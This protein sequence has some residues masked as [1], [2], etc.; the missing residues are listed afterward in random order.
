MFSAFAA[1]TLGN[2]ADH[3]RDWF[4]SLVPSEVIPHLA[5]LISPNSGLYT[6]SP[7]IYS[8]QF[9]QVLTG[10]HMRRTQLER[11]ERAV[12]DSLDPTSGMAIE[13]ADLFA[14]IEKIVPSREFA[15]PYLPL[16]QHMMNGIFT[17]LETA[18]K[19]LAANAWFANTP[20]TARMRPAVF[21]NLQDAF[22]RVKDFHSW[23]QVSDKSVAIFIMNQLAVCAYQVA[24]ITIEADDVELRQRSFEFVETTAADALST[25]L[26]TK[27][28]AWPGDPIWAYESTSLPPHLINARNQAEFVGQYRGLFD[29]RNTVYAN[30][31]LVIIYALIERQRLPGST[32]SFDTILQQACYSTIPGCPAAQ[33][34]GV[35]GYMRL[36]HPLTRIGPIGILFDRGFDCFQVLLPAVDTFLTS[37]LDRNKTATTPSREE[38]QCI[39]ANLFRH[40]DGFITE[41]HWDPDQF[42]TSLLRIYARN[43][44]NHF[45]PSN[46]Y[47][48]ALFRHAQEELAWQGGESDFE[49]FL[50][51]V[52]TVLRGRSKDLGTLRQGRHDAV[53]KKLSNLVFGLLPNNTEFFDRKKNI[54][55][56]D[57]LALWNHYE[58]CLTLYV[59][60]PEEHRPSL[61]LFEHLLDFKS[62]P[63]VIRG[64]TIDMWTAV[65]Q[66][67]VSC[68]V[69]S[70]DTK[71]LAEWAIRMLRCV[72][73][74]L[75]ILNDLDARDRRGYVAVLNTRKDLSISLAHLLR[76]WKVVTIQ[77]LPALVTSIIPRE[78]MLEL[79]NAL[80]VVTT[81]LSQ[82]AALSHETTTR[83]GS[84]YE[85]S[86]YDPYTTAM[87]FLSEL[88]AIP[89]LY[90]DEVRSVADD[91]A[92]ST[93]S[94]ILS[95]DFGYESHSPDG[96]HEV[97]RKVLT[98]VTEQWCIIASLN[99]GLH[100]SWDE[101]LTAPSSLSFDILA[102]TEQSRQCKILFMARMI[103]NNPMNFTMDKLSFYAAWIGRIVLPEHLMAF[104]HSLCTQI[105]RFD[106]PGGLIGPVM[107]NIIPSARVAVPGLEQLQQNRLEIIGGLIARIY[108][109]QI[110]PTTADDS[111]ASSMEESLDSEDLAGLLKLMTNTMKTSWRALTQL[112]R[113]AYLEFIR[114]VLVQ[115]QSYDFLGFQIDKW[116]TDPQE[117]ELPKA[118][119]SFGDH[120][121]L[122]VG[123]VAKPL[124]KSMVRAFRESLIC[125]LASHKEQAWTAETAAAL[126]CGRYAEGALELS[127]TRA[128]QLLT[129]GNQLLVDARLQ[130]QFVRVA[131]PVYIE[132]CPDMPGAA[133]LAS[134]V[135]LV[136]TAI[137]N[138]A[139]SRAEEAGDGEELAEMA[140][141]M[142]HA[143]ERGETCRVEMSE[144]ETALQ[145]WAKEDLM[146]ALE[147][148]NGRETVGWEAKDANEVTEVVAGEE[149]GE[150]EDAMA[151][152]FV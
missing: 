5:S 30:E 95:H 116:F 122:A 108:A 45:V 144:E 55:A 16:P 63:R 127:G 128:P 110:Q 54:K 14:Q 35:I 9:S 134:A 105:H 76:Q 152:L 92:K 46:V 142:L 3:F 84:I 33:L 38:H 62:S 136:L 22:M 23:A 141:S 140:R 79:S 8:G 117:P 20:A 125:A 65:S 101:Y 42:L 129:D 102:D 59:H 151:S 91:L 109:L 13:V 24:D 114:K 67:A 135:A 145:K 50:K 47:R 39:I 40:C 61:R 75:R 113:P 139:Y 143:V 89:T 94:T 52:A 120:F 77:S 1:P 146:G 123:C 71:Y 4:G 48:H 82:T 17:R 19:L 138:N 74:D 60:C 34:A 53:T 72:S 118:D 85:P 32:T 107:D 78:A 64:L 90:A 132:Q 7:Y 73:E 31:T 26:T 18:Q 10:L 43:N 28:L 99:V 83:T 106:P 86:I 58:L 80:S 29:P 56:T 66:H 27:A 69:K 100:R 2:V 51:L 103:R 115:L 70:D 11:G 96:L 44:M 119:G 149:T 131:I 21:Y 41:W 36:I 93:M 98:A 12:I 130:L 148:E 111:Q 147:G 81:H 25:V 6:T 15:D 124:S 68:S 121:K 87:E 37:T 112:H 150:V 126:S 57:Y 137:S 104:E 49:A 133:P 88:A 97:P